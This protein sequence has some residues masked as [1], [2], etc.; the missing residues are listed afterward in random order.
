MLDPN[1]HD[2]VLSLEHLW[3]IGPGK[4]SYPVDEGITVWP[5]AD[6][7]E[8]PRAMRAVRRRAQRGT[9]AGALRS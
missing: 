5:L 9:A 6:V 1:I 3:L 8:L 7:A 4:Q 2:E